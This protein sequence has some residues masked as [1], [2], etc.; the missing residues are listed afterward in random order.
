M[1]SQRLLEAYT[2]DENSHLYV[3]FCHPD[4]HSNLAPAYIQVC[5]LD[6]LRD[7][8]ILYEE[9]LRE[10]HSIKTRLDI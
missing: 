1:S 7:E 5:G 2:A 8:G 10:E 6:P 3:P 4:G 9:M